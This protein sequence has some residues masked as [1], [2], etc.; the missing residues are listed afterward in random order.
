MFKKMNNF[1]SITLAVLFSVAVSGLLVTNLFANETNQV[2]VNWKGTLMNMMR[3][4]DLSSKISLSELKAI[5]HL[6]AV[7]QFENLKGEIQIFDGKPF[8]S[9]AKNKNVAIETT[10]DKNATILVWA[11]VPKWKTIELDM[12]MTATDEIE[13][14]I[15]TMAGRNGVNIYQPFPFMLEG[16]VNSLD[17]HVIDWD[18][19]DNVHS[20]E[21]HIK[22]GPNGTLN[23]SE[24][25]MLGFFSSEHQGIFSHHSSRMHLHFK[26]KDGKLAGFVDKFDLNEKMFLKVPDVR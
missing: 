5:P 25:I 9:I 3:E 12:T 8:N 11:S 23:N 19:N 26:T 14:Y 24:V 20:Y 13:D 2:T 1:T 15:E 7:G 4:N 17:W 10:F 6:Y 21:K 16:T 18:A 22:S